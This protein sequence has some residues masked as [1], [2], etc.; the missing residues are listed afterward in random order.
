MPEHATTQ[1]I[2]SALKNLTVAV[3]ATILLGA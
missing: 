2:L 1:T 3:M